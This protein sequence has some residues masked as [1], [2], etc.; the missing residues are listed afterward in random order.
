M[1]AKLIQHLRG[2]EFRAVSATNGSINI[3]VSG[4]E[5]RFDKLIVPLEDPKPN[6]SEVVQSE[7]E[8]DAEFLNNR[9]GENLKA[10]PG[11]P[12]SDHKS[13]EPQNVECPID[14]RRPA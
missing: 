7:H 13:D 6:E 11:P 1:R 14:D 3:L 4:F 5:N 12:R 9:V 2:Q 10:T 8:I